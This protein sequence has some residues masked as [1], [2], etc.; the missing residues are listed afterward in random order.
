MSRSD[1]IL[2]RFGVGVGG[3]DQA[4]EDAV[5]FSRDRGDEAIPRDLTAEDVAAVR[6]RIYSSDTTLT[7]HRRRI[8]TDTEARTLA[9]RVTSG[10]RY[11]DVDDDVEEANDRLE[12]TYREP[13]F[14]QQQLGVARLNEALERRI[15]G[16]GGGGGGG[17]SA[18]VRAMA[19]NAQRR[20][21]E[22]HT[23]N[24]YTLERRTDATL[25]DRVEDVMLRE[26]MS[27]TLRSDPMCM[28]SASDPMLQ[29]M[30]R[31]PLIAWINRLMMPLQ[32]MTN[33]ERRWQPSAERFI[34]YAL[35][36]GL[37]PRAVYKLNERQIVCLAFAMIE[38]A[39]NSDEERDEEE[40][41]VGVEG[42]ER[43]VMG[44]ES[45]N[46]RLRTL[47]RVNMFL[48]V[49]GVSLEAW[50]ETSAESMC[51]HLARFAYRAYDR[52]EQRAAMRQNGEFK[53][54]RAGVRFQYVCYIYSN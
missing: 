12:R 31:A 20:R 49:H 10:E 9:R 15:G 2:D 19:I 46:T 21:A 44:D 43:T 50:R 37:H 52:V 1:H 5:A 36:A 8:P 25:M 29:Y 42:E 6:Q 39:E 33:D 47:G 41:L 34:T 54:L 53:T 7:G 51:P 14:R 28:I 17:D 11:T 48:A 30:Q 18:V 45:M 16:G 24:V 26:E 35:E 23:E 38:R 13:S 32:F 22:L 3:D 40:S 27:A 4:L